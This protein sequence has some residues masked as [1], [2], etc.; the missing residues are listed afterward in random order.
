MYLL[1]RS[2]AQAEIREQNEIDAI[3]RHLADAGYRPVLRLMV[4][5]ASEAAGVYPGAIGVAPLKRSAPRI[6]QQVDGPMGELLFWAAG[7]KIDRLYVVQPA[8][9]RLEASEIRHH[10]LASALGSFCTAVEAAARTTLDGRRLRGMDFSWKVPRERPSRRYL[11]TAR[12]FNEAELKT[13][14]PE[15]SE[16]ELAAARG[17]VQP[18]IRNFLIELAQVGKA[19]LVDSRLKPEAIKT[20]LEGQLIRK[21]FLV[22]CRQDSHTICR[23]SDRAELERASGEKFSCTVCGRALKDEL[24]QDIFA[25]TDTGRTLVTSS[26]WMTIWV[27]D[28]LVQ[29]G[30]ARETIKWNATA[31]ED[32]LDVMTD[33]LGPRVFL[34]LKDREFGLGDAYPFAIRVGRYGGT[35]GV[36]VTTERVA[37]EAKKF[38]E[39][40]RSKMAARIEMVEGYQEVEAGLR[41]LVNRYSRVGVS[42]FVA[43][44]CEGL[45]MNLNPIV[46]AWMDKVVFDV[47]RNRTCPIPA[48]SSPAENSQLTDPAPN[49]TDQLI[50]V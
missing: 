26:R 8:G 19:R 23:L 47:Q 34:E 42:Q 10:T 1:E 46:S 49:I 6:G 7:D 18:D 12:F 32:E 22:L 3:I 14:R 20:L 4:A 41:R 39:E 25:L 5:A 11:N 45:G 28:L 40:E 38:F 43:E 37:E 50:G 36:V 44:I 17:L 33:A 9:G 24:V 21:E 31:G 35:F 48:P 2:Q 15:Y 27:T 29:S 13:K 30:I 16:Q